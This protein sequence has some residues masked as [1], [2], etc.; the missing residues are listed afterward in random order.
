MNRNTLETLVGALVLAVAAWFLMF[1]MGNNTAISISG[2]NYALTSR[3][4]Q[5]DG[6]AIGTPVRIGG[7]KVGVIT[8]QALDPNT[9]SAIITISLTNEIKIPDDS[10][11]KI[12]SEGLIGGKYLAIL[13]GGSETLLK[14]GEEI[15]YTQ[16][17]INLESLIGKMIFSKDDDK[18]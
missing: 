6:I 12:A 8:D 7:V 14:N 1:F 9:Y 5:A 15:R 18:K 10:I 13:P 3:F 2:D 11:A 16:S 4:E 17:S